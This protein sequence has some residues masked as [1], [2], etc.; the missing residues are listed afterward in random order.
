MHT[1]TIQFLFVAEDA[2]EGGCER[3]TDHPVIHQYSIRQTSLL[4][5]M[6]LRRPTLVD[7]NA[8]VLAVAGKQFKLPPKFDSGSSP[9]YLP[10]HDQL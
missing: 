8:Q 7:T 10:S 4:Y 6:R 1:V 5:H 3:V 2:Q 9:D